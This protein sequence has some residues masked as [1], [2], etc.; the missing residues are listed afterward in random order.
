MN[1]WI[2]RDYFMIPLL[3]DASY[4]AQNLRGLATGF[5]FSNLAEASLAR[6]K[7]K[8]PTEFV[9]FELVWRRERDCLR[10]AQTSIEFHQ[11]IKCWASPLS[12]FLAVA[13]ESKL[14]TLHQ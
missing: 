12:F 14:S 9:D 5:L 4:I 3:G 2:E 6:L 7:N 8:K 10:F 13:L 1:E 11:K